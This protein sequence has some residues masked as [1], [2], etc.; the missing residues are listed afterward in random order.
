MIKTK[1]GKLQI[2]GDLTEVMA[3]VS[4]IVTHLYNN[5]LPETMTQEEAKEMIMHAVECGLMTEEER[6][7]QIFEKLVE[8]LCKV[9]TEMK[10]QGEE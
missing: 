4:V 1:R 7:A 6:N 9:G 10:G 3:D 5:V 8:L 2:K